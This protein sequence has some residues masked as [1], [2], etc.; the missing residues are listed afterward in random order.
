MDIKPIHELKT[1]YDSGMSP[2]EE[3]DPNAVFVSVTTYNYEGEIAHER[4]MS[5]KHQ[6]KA[7]S[8]KESF[9]EED[10]PRGQPDN[11]GQFASKDDGSKK[12]PDKNIGEDDLSK[13]SDYI[14][15]G[16][17]EFEIDGKHYHFT[18]GKSG[19]SLNR[20]LEG[21][22]YRFEKEYNVY[23]G[24]KEWTERKSYDDNGKLVKVETVDKETGIITSAKE[25][26][27]T[28]TMFEMRYNDEDHAR[29]LRDKFI[30]WEHHDKWDKLQE[31]KKKIKDTKDLSY[32]LRDNSQK[33]M[34]LRSKFDLSRKDF[35]DGNITEEQYDKDGRKLE[36]EE[37]AIMDEEHRIELDE[38]H[39]KISEINP[40]A[41]DVLKQNK[42][43]GRN[44]SDYQEKLVKKVERITDNIKKDVSSNK[45]KSWD[46]KRV[47]SDM[48][49]EYHNSGVENNLQFLRMKN[50]TEKRR[51]DEMEAKLLVGDLNENNMWEGD[52]LSGISTLI[53]EKHGNVTKKKDEAMTNMAQRM[54]DGKKGG[55]QFT[56]LN[57]DLAKQYHDEYDKYKKMEDEIP[58]REKRIISS[59]KHYQKMVDDINTDLDYASKKETLSG[60]KE[61]QKSEVMT[62]LI[63][64]R[65]HVYAIDDIKNNQSVPYD[66]INTLYELAKKDTRQNLWIQNNKS[67]F[68][69]QH[70]NYELIAGKGERFQVGEKKFITGAHWSRANSAIRFFNSTTADV[71]KWS[72]HHEKAH[73]IYDALTDAFDAERQ[74]RKEKPF[75]E[76]ERLTE[77][78]DEGTSKDIFGDYFTSYLTSWNKGDRKGKVRNMHTEAFAAITDIR[79]DKRGGHSGY[80]LLKEL[81]PDLVKN[82]EVLMGEEGNVYE[83][84][85]KEV[86]KK[87]DNRVI[88]QQMFYLDNKNNF[89]KKK[90]AVKIWRN[91]YNSVG[92]LVEK[93]K[94]IMDS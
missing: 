43:I 54:L 67:S 48:A 40:D 49:V 35:R 1:F 85:A 8:S 6:K 22:Q 60:L 7:L 41:W 52:G 92:K 29:V 44:L 74:S 45:I 79:H 16:Y 11:A 34:E 63:T 66:A 82:Y 26:D 86:E 14:K 39:D 89:V 38:K 83:K 20:D 37:F 65:Q 30:S 81:Y 12:S 64:K 32:Y 42:K 28:G 53:S 46:I 5:L 10:H 13:D 23:D 3:G 18:S 4:L 31:D 58:D 19:G 80:N 73:S 55:T 57:D 25:P 9:N 69:K 47:S 59:E 21:N 91:G 84:F 88:S 93:K 87:V 36:K 62:P 51:I 90:H 75:K 2:V 15:D 70:M 68:E 71:V 61:R 94:F 50:I 78:I 77:K 56:I 76:F 24:D 17:D 27:L 33:R 72:Y